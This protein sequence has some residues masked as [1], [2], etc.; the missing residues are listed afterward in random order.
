M[1]TTKLSLPQL[2]ATTL[3]NSLGAKP[4]KWSQLAGNGL[5]DTTRIA[6]S[7]A[8]MWIDILEQNRDEILRALTTYEDE[9]HHLRTA[10]AN[11]DWTDLRT[12][13]ERGKAWRDS[14]RP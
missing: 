4:A 3:G 12:R 14:L 7:D 10:L 2:V 6:A 13:I 5:K 11:R 1:S 9:L 8:S